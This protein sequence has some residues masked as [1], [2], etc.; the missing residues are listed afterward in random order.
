MTDPSPLQLDEQGRLEFPCVFPVKA[1]THVRDRAL[2]RVV[3]EIVRHA[4]AC[5][6]DA[7]QI[8][9]SR[10]GRFQSLTIEV[11]VESRDQLE[12]VYAGLRTLDIVVMT[13]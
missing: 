4:P 12:A 5:N 11:R 1:L 6:R 10:N 3:D 7:I 13:L 9:P 2:E 8:R